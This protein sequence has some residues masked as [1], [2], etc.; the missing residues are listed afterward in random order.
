MPRDILTFLAPTG[1]WQFTSAP[2]EG[3]TTD[4]LRTTAAKLNAPQRSTMDTSDK[5]FTLA[6]GGGPIWGSR[7][8][9][10]KSRQ[11]DTEIPNE[12][13][14]SCWLLWLARLNVA[15]GILTTGSLP[16]PLCAVPKRVQA[17]A[18]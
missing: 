18:G 9:E 1:V 2:A 10:F 5:W 8:R 6:N 14:F 12:S 15:T 13:R 7:G 16:E 4:Q 3:E 11:P 17:S